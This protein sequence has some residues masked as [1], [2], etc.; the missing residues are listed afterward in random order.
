[1]FRAL[2]GSCTDTAQSTHLL[3]RFTPARYSPILNV[4]IDSHSLYTLE[5]TEVVSQS[6]RQP[7]VSVHE[8]HSQVV[9]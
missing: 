1:L 2:W 3:I 8:V 4:Q 9:S 7:Q 5:N 6:L